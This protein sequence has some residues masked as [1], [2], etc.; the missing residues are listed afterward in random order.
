M[1]P[2]FLSDTTKIIEEKPE[3]G[4]DAPS[5]CEEEWAGQEELEGGFAS[6]SPAEKRFE[7]LFCVMVVCGGMVLLQLIWQIAELTSR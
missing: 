5:A 6:L 4:I 2:S 3:L 7:V 1:N